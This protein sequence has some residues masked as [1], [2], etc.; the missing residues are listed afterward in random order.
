MPPGEI[1]HFYPNFNMLCYQK[2]KNT[3]NLCF[4]KKYNLILI[5]SKSPKFRIDNDGLLGLFFFHAHFMYF[6][7]HASLL[8]FFVFILFLS[9]CSHVLVFWKKLVN[10][11]HISYSHIGWNMFFLQCNYNCTM[12]IWNEKQKI[13][14]HW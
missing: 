5:M 7:T 13:V 6:H 1:T 14:K 11:F 10:E 8:I 3:K 4:K 2:E 9:C 12:C